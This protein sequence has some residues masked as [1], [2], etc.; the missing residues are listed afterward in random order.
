MTSRQFTLLLIL[1]ALGA[2]LLALMLG[3][4]AIDP[5]TAA[6]ALGG[7]GD[8]AARTILIDIRLPRA[9]AALLAG[10]ALGI[11]GAAL[12]ALLRNPLAE[13]GVLGVSASA[14]TC[15]T[16]AIYFG[17]AA[18]GAWVVPLASLV[19]ALAATLIL[20]GAAM[21]LRGV[22]SLLLLGIALT[23]FAGAVM[24]LF[25]NLAPN[26]FSLSDLINWTAGS[27][28]NRDWQDCVVSAPFILGGIALLVTQR[29][30]LSLLLLG[31]E[32]AFSHGL[33]LRTTR[34]T[35][36]IGTGLATAGSVA[37]AGMIGFVG[38]VAPH[39]VRL[40]LRNDAGASLIP[41]AIMGGVMTLLADVGVRLFPWGNMLHLGT[42]AALLGAPVFVLLVLRWGN[43][44]HG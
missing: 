4:V 31:D 25:V 41:A 8:D 13:P 7:G 24:A 1:C 23:A 38:L 36:V 15:A 32:A 6:R 18:I 26:P 5:M 37:L 43:V 39:A 40:F 30:N 12:Q 17:L 27:V 21:R 33:D 14:T 29:R 16:A 35:I 2:L 19:G 28:A 10:G 3:P 22:A 44:R 42:I 34:L 9:I 20:S 11:S